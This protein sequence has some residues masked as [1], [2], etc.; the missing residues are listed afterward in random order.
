M[1]FMKPVYAIADF[2]VVETTNGTEVVPAEYF[3]QE[4]LGEAVSGQIEGEPELVQAK[5]FCRLSAPGYLDATEWAG[6]FDTM[7]EARAYIVE[8]YE[9]D[10]ESGEPLDA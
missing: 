7:D 4:Q 2:W 5:W 3:T 8:T 9:V 10:P 6:P 1:A